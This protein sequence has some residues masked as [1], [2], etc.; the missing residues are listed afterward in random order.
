MKLPIERLTDTPATF[1]PAL[2]FGTGGEAQAIAIHDLNAD[3][4]P[5]VATANPGTND[6]SI[7]F[8]Q[9]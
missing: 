6:I 3:G 8:N 4:K 7:L 5:D 1:E 9:R 2:R